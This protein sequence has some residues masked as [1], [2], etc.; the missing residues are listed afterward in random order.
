MVTPLIPRSKLTEVFFF[1]GCSGERREEN[2][3]KNKNLKLMDA[4][5]I[6]QSKLQRSQELLQLKLPQGLL[7]SDCLF[8]EPAVVLLHMRLTKA[9]CFVQEN[10]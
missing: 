10:N 7:P 5:G 2:E 9:C 6:Y 8:L 1:L 4:L 3:K